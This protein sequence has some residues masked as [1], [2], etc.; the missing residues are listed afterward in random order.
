MWVFKI[1]QCGQKP[2][3]RFATTRW[4]NQ[5]C[6]FIVDAVLQHLQL[7][8]TRRPTPR[9]EPV[10]ESGREHVSFTTLPFLPCYRGG[11]FAEREQEGP[12][13]GNENL[14]G[15]NSCCSTP[16]CLLR[17]LSSPVVGEEKFIPPD[18][19]QL[20]NAQLP[21]SPIYPTPMHRAK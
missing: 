7:V 5:Q 1:N 8:H 18:I 13:F 4:R 16:S 2:R 14:V 15:R 11:Q 6:A 17:R 19:L 20:P 3:K 21:L 9:A 12:V 10:A